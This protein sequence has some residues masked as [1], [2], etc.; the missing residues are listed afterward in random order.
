MHVSYGFKLNPMAY[1]KTQK[2]IYKKL[3]KKLQ[4]FMQ[5]Q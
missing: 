1:T 2:S 4:K 5:E 3:T